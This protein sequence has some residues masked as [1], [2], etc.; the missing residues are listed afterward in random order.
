MAFSEFTEKTKEYLKSLRYLKDYASFDLY[1]S[2]NWVIP[3]KFVETIEVIKQEKSDRPNTN[4]YSFVVK[5]EKSGV[6]S[7]EQ[8][9]DNI[10]KY[11]KEREEKEKLFKEKIEELKSVFENKNVDELKK[12]YFEIDNNT[13]LLNNEEIIENEQQNDPE[14]DGGHA[15]VVQEGT[16]EG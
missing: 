5:N 13:T 3:K 2:N 4:L 11:N 8:A 7:L 10:F 9:V 6:K 12:L 1:L 16:I 14:G 15:V